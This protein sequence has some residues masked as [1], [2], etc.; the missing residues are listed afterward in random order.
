MRPVIVVV[1]FNR[2]RS[3]Q[4]LLTF[5]SKAQYPDKNITLIIS[6]DRGDNQNVLN[7][8]NDFVWEFG[9]KIVDYQKE[10]LKLRKHILKCGNW[11][12]KYGSVIVLEDDL[13]VS[14]YFYN[15]AVQALSFS[16][17]REYIGG[18][19]LYNHRWNVNVSEPFEIMDDPY[20]IWYFQFASSWGQAW[21][22]TQWK[23][24]KKWY[25]INESKDLHASDMPKFVANWSSSS[26]LKYFIKYL[27]ES[28]KYFIYPKKSLTSNFSDAGTHVNSDNTNY[29]VPL[30]ECKRVYH[31]SELEESRCVY[32]AFFESQ[33]MIDIHEIKTT[34]ITIDL[35]GSKTDPKTRYWLSRK[36]LNYAIVASYGCS[37]R[38][39]EANIMYDIPGEDFF[40]YDTSIE[41][42]NSRKFNA[43]R[44]SVFNHRYI[45]LKDYLPIF[46]TF[47]DAVSMG[48]RKRLKYRS[49]K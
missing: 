25:V 1:A 49:K 7:I 28:D 19:S 26:W 12:E 45:L 10:N 17:N 20:D 36:I 9:E 24:F 42:K 16:E 37:M 4:R 40:L 23:N 35:Y 39:H 29:Q 43:K 21:T 46:E 5:L 27:I 3:L 14:P 38:P 47:V 15:Y 34:D 48:I 41:E 44:K 18:I 8:A 22:A 32:D 11:S 13:I 31:F 33:R 2:P 30:D 6:I